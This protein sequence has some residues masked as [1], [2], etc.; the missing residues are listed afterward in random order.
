MR[1][2]TGTYKNT[3]TD[4]LHDLLSSKLRTSKLIFQHLSTLRISMSTSAQTN[5]QTT[6]W[7]W[8]T[9]LFPRRIMYY[10]RAKSL[11]SSI[12]QA[13]NI[14]LIPVVS[15]N[16]ARVSAPGYEDRPPNSM[17]PCLRIEKMNAPPFFIHESGAILEWFEDIF[18]FEQGYKDLRGTDALQRARTRD[19]LNLLTDAIVWTGVK[20][21]HS[22]SSSLSWS[23]LTRE[24]WSETAAKDAQNR[25]QYYLSRLEEWVTPA[26]QKGSKSLSGL[27]VEVTLAD[28]AV[29]AMVQYQ[30]ENIGRDWIAGHKN[31]REW[32]E[33]AK[34]EAWFVSREQLDE[35]ERVGF[36]VL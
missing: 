26:I 15:A 10:L 31:L 25:V 17:L 6:L 7:L 11:T 22:D 12:L 5:P 33:R 3:P 23:G 14:R 19:I 24:Q 13:H 30:E 34:Q 32:C 28:F 16:G 18:G 36:E 27:E 2:Q 35:M 8:P 21:I 4:P 9:G 29:M 1:S 20:I